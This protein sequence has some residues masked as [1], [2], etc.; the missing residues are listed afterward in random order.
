MEKRLSVGQSVWL[1]DVLFPHRVILKGNILLMENTPWPF[2]L[3]FH[4]LDG[5]GTGQGTSRVPAGL[6][7]CH[8]HCHPHPVTVVTIGTGDI[9]HLQNCGRKGK[10]SGGVFSRV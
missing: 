6:S 2:P 4:S 5:C 10:P 8:H 3:L 1:F 7:P 9:K